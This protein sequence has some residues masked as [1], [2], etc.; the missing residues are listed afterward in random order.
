MQQALLV[1][2]HQMP[3]FIDIA[4]PEVEKTKEWELYG[5]LTRSSP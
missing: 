4:T 5:K 3:F 1:L 2:V